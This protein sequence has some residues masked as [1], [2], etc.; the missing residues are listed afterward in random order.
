LYKSSFQN[1]SEVMLEVCTAYT[2]TSA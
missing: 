1:L 2:D